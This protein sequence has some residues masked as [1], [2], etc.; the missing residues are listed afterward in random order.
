[1]NAFG[2]VLSFCCMMFALF[3]LRVRSRML[4]RMA[5]GG[6]ARPMLMSHKSA[7]R[8]AAIMA[9]VAWLTMGLVA[10]DTIRKHK[11]HRQESTDAPS[12]KASVAH[13]GVWEYT[14]PD[15]GVIQYNGT[16]DPQTH[17]VGSEQWR[18]SQQDRL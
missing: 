8:A 9:A 3:E 7:L 16:K 10:M 15:G 14:A 5:A 12:Q 1:M 18:A 4:E 13:S 17:F 11:S 6:E 2:V